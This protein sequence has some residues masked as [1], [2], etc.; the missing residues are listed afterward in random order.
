MWGIKDFNFLAFIQAEKLLRAQG[1]EVF[2]PAQRDLEHYG[3]GICNSPTGDFKDIAHL[4]FSLRETL[5][6]DVK[7]ICEEAEAIVLLPRWEKSKGA[8]AEKML[9]EALGLDVFYY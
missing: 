4:N 5:A 1:H 9:A 2:N 8:C 3:I 6:A 7:Y